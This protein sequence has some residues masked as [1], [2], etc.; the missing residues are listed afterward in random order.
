[1][2]LGWCAG[3]CLD[4]IRILTQMTSYC[5]SRTAEK[6]RLCFAHSCVHQP[7]TSQ[8]SSSVLYTELLSYSYP[9]STCNLWPCFVLVCFLS[10]CLRVTWV[11]ENCF[12]SLGSNPFLSSPVPPP[13][14][15]KAPR[16]E[17]TELARGWMIDWVNEQLFQQVWALC[18][19]CWD[20]G[21]LLCVLTPRSVCLVF[22]FR[23]LPA[24]QA[25][26]YLGHSLIP[27]RQGIQQFKMSD[28]NEPS[29]EMIS[30]WK[31][32]NCEG[33]KR[34]QVSLPQK[35]CSQGQLPTLPNCTDD[36]RSVS[37]H[38]LS[39][40]LRSGALGFCFLGPYVWTSSS[41]ITQELV[42]NECMILCPP[43]C[44]K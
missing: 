13:L 8:C 12:P 26:G 21:H 6:S 36:L 28:C 41:S 32:E 39:H 1:M 3:P 16:T 29:Y 33:K 20:T 34:T 31:G 19:V 2:L 37:W 24:S 17:H 42:R 5:A 40:T 14:P 43:R 4:Y 15:P 18:Q 25:P 27:L 11:K 9:N 44:A 7:S 35:Y 22:S 30:I 23:S 38:W 10:L